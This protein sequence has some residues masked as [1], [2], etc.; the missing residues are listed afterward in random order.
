MTRAAGT[1]RLVGN[2]WRGRVILRALDPATGKRQRRDLRVTFGR[3]IRTAAAA[4]RALDRHL[5]QLGLAD[6][7]PTRGK[8]PGA[9]TLAEFVDRHF[10]HHMIALA[11]QS[12]ARYSSEI[13]RILLPALGDT[14]VLAVNLAQVQALAAQ[15]A[16]EKRA[17]SSI[18]GTIR[19]LLRI[20]A[21]AHDLGLA[22]APPSARKLSLPRSSAPTLPPRVYSPDETRALLAAAQPLWFKAY[23]TAMAYA[24]LR[25][26]EAAGICWEDVDLDR[27]TIVI[28]RQAAGGELVRLKTRSSGARLPL[29]RT[30]AAVLRQY[31]AE[32]GAPTDGPLFPAP[33]GGP[34]SVEGIRKHH[35][36]PLLH[37]LNVKPAGFHGL[38]HSF[39]HRL[40]RS[41]AN[42]E[43]VRRLLRH[44]S[45]SMVL[46]YSQDIGA[47]D[48]TQAIERLPP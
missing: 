44:A 28:C 27:A 2:R 34:R 4:R 18:A 36:Q 25:A 29:H 6:T 8:G 5:E 7:F 12:R 37:Q 3:E 38:R 16:G 17:A 40:W 1:V 9:L 10:A 39:A 13:R 11:P 31:H 42:A 22:P 43:S 41:G 26:S 35:W 30:L 33:R 45:L 47:V 15:L 32:L 46:R 23:L 21:V 48:L 19:L 20:L 14:P 24:G